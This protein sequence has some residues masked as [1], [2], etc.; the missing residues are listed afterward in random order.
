MRL[1]V[2]GAFQGKTAYA[3]S[4]GMA[5]P[6]EITDGAVCELEELYRCKC[7]RHFHLWVKRALEAG[8]SL[9]TL[10]QKLAKR[11]P[12]LVLITDELGCGVVPV[13]AFDRTWRE[14]HGRICCLLAARAGEVHRVL[15]G[16]GMVIRHV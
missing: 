16:I 12:E 1:I 14:T 9:D 13:D 10:D 5:R 15:C 7:I 8:W 4:A 2:G 3:V 6:E 11:N